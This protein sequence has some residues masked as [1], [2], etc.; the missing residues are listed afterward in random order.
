MRVLIVVAMLFALPAEAQVRRCID[1]NGNV[2]YQDQPCPGRSTGAWVKK[3]MD[4]QTHGGESAAAIERRAAAIREANH[5]A[6]VDGPESYSENHYHHRYRLPELRIPRQVG[7][8]PLR[9]GVSV[10]QGYI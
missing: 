3:R 4:S 8:L 1:A 9:Q 6:A 2:A 7:A 10:T 5:A